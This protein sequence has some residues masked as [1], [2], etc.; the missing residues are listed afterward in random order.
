MKN[1]QIESLLTNAGT[2]LNMMNGLNINRDSIAIHSATHKEASIKFEA[3]REKRQNE[4]YWKTLSQEEQRVMM[5]NAQNLYGVLEEL[6][7]EIDYL[8]MSK[9]PTFISN[10]VSE[11]NHAF[12]L[13]EWL[14]EEVGKSGRTILPKFTALRTNTFD[15]GK[16]KNQI[17]SLYSE[18]EAIGHDFYVD[19]I[20][21]PEDQ[22]GIG[23]ELMLVPIADH[24]ITSACWLNK[25]KQRLLTEALPELKVIKMPEEVKPTVPA[26]PEVETLK[27]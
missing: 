6:R 8:D 23:V 20:H 3:L 13:L 17:D 2:I 11:L 22:L 7:K 16:Y 4:E 15:K 26:S 14:S 24:L 5:E 18:L 9:Q 1:N 19:H 10:A 12:L 27:N 25:E 21:V